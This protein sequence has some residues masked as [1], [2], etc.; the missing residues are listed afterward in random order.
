MSVCKFI[1]KF[2]ISLTSLKIKVHNHLKKFIFFYKILV[3]K[4]FAIFFKTLLEIKKENAKSTT[5][6]LQ[7]NVT[8]IIVDEFQ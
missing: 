7:Y 3:S 4:T 8:I 6:C 2:V 5:T 1:V